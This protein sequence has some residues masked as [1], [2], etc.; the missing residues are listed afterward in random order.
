[1]GSESDREPA[2]PGGATGE[3]DARDRGGESRQE[4]GDNQLTSHFSE[5]ELERIEELADREDLNC[6]WVLKRLLVNRQD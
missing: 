1:M 6:R 5:R 2:N 4:P 3:Y